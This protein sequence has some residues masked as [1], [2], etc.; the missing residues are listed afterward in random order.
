VK[1][2]GR[3]FL[4]V[5]NKRAAPALSDAIA[6][7]INATV[8]DVGVFL[9][10]HK[11]R[12]LRIVMVTSEKRVEALPHVPTANKDAPGLVATNWPGVFAPAN[13]PQHI[14]QKINAALA[15]IT[16]RDE[17]RTAFQ[18]ASALEGPEKF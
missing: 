18:K 17:V 10:M 15:Q 7:R 1:A 13:T 9:S 8:A 11:E 2:T 3:D 16:A 4:N 14:V 6:G 12:Q 5:P